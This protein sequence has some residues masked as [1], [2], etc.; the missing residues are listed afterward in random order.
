MTLQNLPTVQLDDINHRRRHREL[1]NLVLQHQHDDSRVRTPAEVAAGIIPVNYAYAPEDTRRFEIADDGVTNVKAIFQHLFSLNKPLYIPKPAVSYYLGQLGDDE[2]VFD[3]TGLDGVRIYGNRALFTFENPA[4]VNARLFNLDGT[5]NVDIDG[6]LA[7]C[8]DYTIAG[9]L[10]LGVVVVGAADGADPCTDVRIRIEATTCLAGIEI[11]RAGSGR[12]T[13]F[14]IDIETTEC[15]YGAVFGGD[16][17]VVNGRVR[18]SG[19]VR[20][21]FLYEVKDHNVDVISSDV[22]S[23]SGGDLAIKAFQDGSVTENIL[24][25]Y[26]ARDTNSTASAVLI[27]TSTVDAETCT[28]R[29]IDLW[30]DDSGNTTGSSVFIN[31]TRDGSNEDPTTC[32]ID[33]I[34]V[35]GP[36]RQQIAFGTKPSVLGRILQQTGVEVSARPS[37]WSFDSRGWV[38]KQGDGN[39]W[40]CAKFADS[41]E[42]DIPVGALVSDNVEFMMEITVCTNADLGLTSG[43]LQKLERFSVCGFV[44]SGTVT[45]RTQTS[46]YNHTTSANIT[47]TITASTGFVRITVTGSAVTSDG[48]CAARYGFI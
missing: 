3:L 42:I 8:T 15:Y 38:F 14:D 46:H 27:E 41:T 2:S 23:G 31:A 33:N 5:T 36:L 39:Y 26:S 11:F 45:L 32:T 17:D 25:R 4:S 19:A 13:R 18:T 47:H 48:V 22:H 43:S 30:V 37:F 28:I 7:E 44:A 34:W 21:Y 24:V 20:S 16:G 40:Q 12:H 1:T 35:R 6:I 9:D 10:T 29:N